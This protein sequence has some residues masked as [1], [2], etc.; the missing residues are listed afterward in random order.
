MAVTTTLAPLVEA[1]LVTRLQARAGLAGVLVDSGPLG[2][3]TDGHIEYI[4]IGG[5]LDQQATIQSTEA[6]SS[7]GNLRRQETIVIDCL[8]FVQVTGAGG[9]DIRT[10]SARAHA[11]LAEVATELRDDP[12]LGG[13]IDRNAQFGG[14]WSEQRFAGSGTRASAIRFQVTYMATLPRT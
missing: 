13:L 4:E 9:A 3:S 10:A 6:W 12:D 2:A 5:S 14:E 11:I 8:V 7:L 1:E